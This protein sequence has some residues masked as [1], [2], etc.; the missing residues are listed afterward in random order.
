VYGASD[1]TYV[2][3]VRL[4]LDE[5]QVPYE[6]VNVDVFASGGPPADYLKLHP[7]GRI[8][9]FEHDGFC[10]YEAVPIARYIDE[11]FSGP[12]LQPGNAR[13]SAHESNHRHP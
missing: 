4:T 6:L 2:R 13:T 9:A 3:T 10:M 7:F 8:P 1:S 5:K 12:P 11:V